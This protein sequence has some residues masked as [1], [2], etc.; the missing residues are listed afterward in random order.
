MLYIIY[1]GKLFII[2]SITEYISNI[3]KLSN[4][5][6]SSKIMFII[7]LV[8]TILDISNAIETKKIDSKIYC[9]SK[10]NDAS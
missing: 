3:Y 10:S 2:I 1:R 8:Y 5:M 6:L 7:L 4:I 9:S